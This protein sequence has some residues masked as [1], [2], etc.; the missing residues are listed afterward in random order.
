MLEAP[1]GQT[2]WRRGVLGQAWGR[3]G[4][5]QLAGGRDGQHIC[6]SAGDSLALGPPGVPAPQML[7]VEAGPSHES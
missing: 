7:K 3:G 6:L 5:G 2:D 4:K 1:G